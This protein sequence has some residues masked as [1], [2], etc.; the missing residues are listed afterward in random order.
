MIHLLC[1]Y[2]VFISFCHIQSSIICEF[3]LSKA[4]NKHMEG[5]FFILFFSGCAFSFNKIYF[6]FFQEF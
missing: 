4:E 6:F 1:L 5:L 3:K 2:Y